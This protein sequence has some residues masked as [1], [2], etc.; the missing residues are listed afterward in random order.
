MQLKPLFFAFALAISPYGMGQDTR[1]NQREATNE[2][3]KTRSTLERFEHD[4]LDTAAEKEQKRL[5]LQQRRERLLR[6]LDTVSISKSM[7]RNLIRDLDKNPF[8]KRLKQFLVQYR[9]D[10][11][12]LRSGP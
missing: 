10:T 2:L 6:Y 7:R 9:R 8:S 11:A 4:L 12:P 1:A 5:T 3:H